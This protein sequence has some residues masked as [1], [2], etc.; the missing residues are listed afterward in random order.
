[1]RSG[2]VCQIEKSLD[3]FGIATLSQTNQRLIHAADIG[4]DDLDALQTRVMAEFRL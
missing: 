2:A 4:P 3:Q 1:M